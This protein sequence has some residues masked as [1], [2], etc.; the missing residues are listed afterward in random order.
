MRYLLLAALLF[1]GCGGGSGGSVKVEGK[2]T[3]PSPPLPS[4]GVRV[5]EQQH[6]LENHL[7]LDLPKSGGAVSGDGAF[8]GTLG[9]N[10]TPPDPSSCV[11]ARNGSFT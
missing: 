11:V 6:A 8:D 5:C 7:T 4:E 1:V 10:N 9:P 2:F 3:C